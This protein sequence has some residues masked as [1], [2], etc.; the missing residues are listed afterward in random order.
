MSSSSTLSEIHDQPL[1]RL[2]TVVIVVGDPGGGI[3]GGGG[4]GVGGGGDGEGE[5][6][7]GKGGGGGGGGEGGGGGGGDGGGDGGDGGG[8]RPEP[9]RSR[10]GSPH[11][12]NVTALIAR[13][14]QTIAAPE[15]LHGW[16]GTS[17]RHD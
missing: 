7:G 5:G 1:L 15:E 6:G 9:S 17:M 4:D 13:H 12:R 3:I 14:P 10:G 16:P 11:A 2:M 8:G